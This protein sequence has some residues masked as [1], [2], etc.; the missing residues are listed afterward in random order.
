MRRR[1]KHEAMSIDQRRK[2]VDYEG[3]TLVAVFVPFVVEFSL[4]PD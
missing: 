4:R 2:F 3:P 1:G